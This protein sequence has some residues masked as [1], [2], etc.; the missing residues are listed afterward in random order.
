MLRK[1][2]QE[3][4]G[5]HFFNPNDPKELAGQMKL[6]IQGDTSSLNIIPKK[7]IE[8]PVTH[9]WKELFQTLFI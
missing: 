3:A 8:E 7:V 9:S 6:L 4:S 1:Q 2:R 5:L